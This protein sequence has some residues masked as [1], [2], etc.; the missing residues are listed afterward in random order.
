MTQRK[1]AKKVSKGTSVGARPIPLTE[2]EK[3]RLGH[4]IL[5][6]IK[7]V[8]CSAWRGVQSV[9]E[10]FDKAQAEENRRLHPHLFQDGFR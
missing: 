4:G 9:R 6:R 2:G 3:I 5:D 7:P 10:P 8:E 1:R